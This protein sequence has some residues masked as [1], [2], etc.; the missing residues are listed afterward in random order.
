MLSLGVGLD[1]N[2]NL[3]LCV[4]ETEPYHGRMHFFI[5]LERFRIAHDFIHGK[6]FV[7]YS[8]LIIVEL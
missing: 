1:V 8:I 6:H 3:L 2:L 4:A 5:C 7:V